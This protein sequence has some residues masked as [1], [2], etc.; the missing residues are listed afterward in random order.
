MQLEGYEPLSGRSRWAQRALVAV[1]IIEAFAILSG[2]AAYSLYGHDVITQDELDTTSLRE[3]IVA[4]VYVLVFA[5]AAVLFIRWFRRAYRNLPALG[6]GTLRF[7]PGWTIWAWFVPLL[8]LWRPK[9]IANDIWRASDPDAPPHQGAQWHENPVPALFQWW[10]GVFI[11]TT[12]LDNIA[13]RVDWR[14]DDVPA[15]RDAAKAFLA[16]DSAGLIGAILALLVVRRT[17]ARQEARAARL[18][19][20]AETA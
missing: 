13:F 3:G 1:V 20:A 12:F 9:Q 7:R 19:E 4:L 2:Y 5:A 16:A 10:W 17:T 8:S 15:Y 18:A 14:A 6:I 11:V